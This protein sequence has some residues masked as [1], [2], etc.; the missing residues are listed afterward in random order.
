MH[1][2]CFGG[3]WFS[4]LDRSEKKS[5]FSFRKLKEEKLSGRIFFFNPSSPQAFASSYIER[6]FTRIRLLVMVSLVTGEAN[7]KTTM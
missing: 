6:M 4:G 2:F 1:A 5:G 7:L 3:L